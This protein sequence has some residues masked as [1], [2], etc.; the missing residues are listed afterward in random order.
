MNVLEEL[1]EFMERDGETRDWS[2]DSS[3]AKIYWIIA[4]WGLANDDIAEKFRWGNNYGI[5]W[6]LNMKSL[7]FLSNLQNI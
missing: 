3:L 2:S 5:N 6:I 4:G 7:S 1:R